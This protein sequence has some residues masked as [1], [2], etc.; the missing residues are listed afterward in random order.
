M[1][2]RAMGTE[3]ANNNQ[4]ATGSTKADSGWGESVKEATT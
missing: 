2:T 3:K 4:Q 1:A